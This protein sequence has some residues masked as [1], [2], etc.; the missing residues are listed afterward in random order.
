MSLRIN[1]N[2]AALQAH[3]SMINNDLRLNSSL[4]RLSTGLRINKAADDAAGMQIADSLKAQHLGIG[5]AV[6]NAND[7]ISIVQT[8]DGALQESIN[9][10]NTIKT[11]AIQAASDGQTVNTRKAIQADI[12]KL[13]EELDTIAKTTSFN[14]Q[15]LLSG[16]FT[17]KKIQIGAYSNETADISIGSTES[18]KTGHVSHANLSLAGDGGE[19][20]LTITSSITG[21]KITLNKVD[22]L[23][24]NSAQN[25]MGGLA[26]EVNRYSSVT[27]IK[28]T[29]VVKTTTGTAINAGTTGSTFSING[30]NIGAISVTANDGTGSLISAINGKTTE[31]GVEASMNNDGTMTLSS[32]DGRAIKIEG[33]ISDVFGS[34]SSQMS[35]YGYLSLVQ[36]G[37]SQFQ[38]SGIGAGATG[39]DI[40]IDSDVTTAED[41][42][43]A[44]GTTIEFGSKMATGTILG[45]TALVEGQIDSSQLDYKLKSG[46]SLYA[47]TTIAQGTVLGGE[48]TLSGLTIDSTAGTTAIAQDMLVSDGSTLMENTTLGQG[49]VVTTEFTTTSSGSVLTYKVGDVL[50]SAVKL[51]RDVTLNADMVLKYSST[52]ADSSHIK[53]G[54]TLNTGTV[55]GAALEIG[56]TY[57]STSNA[58]ITANT[59]TT[60]DLV[61]SNAGD[62][63]L[64]QS[65]GLAV[66]KAG[67]YLESGSVLQIKNGSTSWS[68]PTLYTTTGVIETGDTVVSSAQ[69]FTLSRGQVLSN[70]L[71][72]GSTVGAS[73]IKQGSILTAGFDDNAALQANFTDAASVT[74]S[75]SI[76]SQDMTLKNGSE[77]AAGS[78]MLSGST[79]GDATY[80]MGGSLNNT[81]SDVVTND[82][83]RLSAG[84][85]LQSG[86]IY[87]E[88]ST[89]GGTIT[90]HGD[91]ELTGD[92]TI[93]KGS[94]LTDT[95]MLKAGTMV[96]QD[97]TLA[98]SNAGGGT[99]IDLKAGDVLTEDLYITSSTGVTL[100]ASMMLLEGSNID[101]GSALSI[102]TANAGTVGLS[103][104][105]NDRLSDLN[106]LTQEGAQLAIDIAEAALK[107]L[108]NTKAS[109]GSIQ[110]QLSS[111]VA[112]L[113]VTQTNV[114]AS[115]SAI[116][117]VDFAAESGNFAKMQLLSQT[118][119]Y[120]L[121]QAN[122]QSQNIMSLLQ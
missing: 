115:E 80:I 46:S 102:N 51:T 76:L 88:G 29:E 9:I 121:A 3:K 89:I 81:K 30:V 49:T 109:I 75:T 90:V 77:L 41:S 86:S 24:N 122:A 73:T 103:D 1:T 94:I 32:T 100:S 91:T 63:T 54:S 40:T 66:I 22:I 84:S 52:A 118:S 53:A 16:A 116:R 33:A 2:V 67:S 37:T 17:N 97:I 120:A 119:A 39:A 96:N 82:L 57:A 21:E 113:S 50:S 45:G 87:A 14:G 108:D 12:D 55:A 13:M 111:T 60:T 65:D 107:D 70:D 25:G 92:M 43:L 79:M 10:V 48:I 56:Y 18:T 59:A 38:I 11:K 42:T 26:D 85:L 93:E 36:H 20:Q 69:T 62:M 106:V 78:K 4:E 61:L 34:T 83:T 47:T 19:V 31:H 114:Q 101:D 58:T 72:L 15:K 27:G 7:G 95:T 5:Q 8:A 71:T 99:S 110:N 64:Q 117:D 6:R 23:K 28:A 105:E 74:L 112:N 35:T 68:G 44:S 98:T 104:I